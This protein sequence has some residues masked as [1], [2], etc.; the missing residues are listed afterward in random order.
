[1]GP[2]GKFLLLVLEA[3]PKVGTVTWVWKGGSWVQTCSGPQK[4]TQAALELQ[5]QGQGYRPECASVA[6]GAARKSAGMLVKD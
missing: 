4:F 3:G 6:V 2:L 5:I 1:M